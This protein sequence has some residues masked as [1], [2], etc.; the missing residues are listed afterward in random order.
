MTNWLALAT[1]I[2]ETLNGEFNGDDVSVVFGVPT[3]SDADAATIVVADGSW[4]SEDNWTGSRL[5][6]TLRVQLLVAVADAVDDHAEVDAQAFDLL[7]RAWRAI[8]AASAPVCQVTTTGGDVIH[9]MG[10]NRRLVII[11]VDIEATGFTRS[12]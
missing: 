7:R 6:E 2:V 4:T 1:W 12:E 11:R 3:Q 9:E 8:S 5:D 10:S